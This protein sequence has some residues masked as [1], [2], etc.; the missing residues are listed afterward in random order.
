MRQFSFIYR[1]VEAIE[2]QLPRKLD[3]SAL[4]AILNVSRW[5]LQHEFKRFTGMSVGRYYRLRLL[6]QAIGDVA[7]SDKRIIDIALDFGFESQEAFYRAVKQSFEVSPKN[8][9][10]TPA[11]AKMIGIPPINVHYLE[12]FQIVE[13]E[14]PTEVFFPAR[15][16][17][18]VSRNFA[19]VFFDQKEVSDGVALLW[20]RF[21]HE[22]CHWLHENRQ[23]FTLEYRNNCSGRSGQ[24]QMLA[25]CD[26]TEQATAHPLAKVSISKRKMWQFTLPNEEFIP[27]LFVYFNQV[28]CQQ[29]KLTLRR[30][31]FIWQLD[32]QGKLRFWVELKQAEARLALPSSVKFLDESMTLKPRLVGVLNMQTIPSHLVQKGQR[33][34]YVL[35]RYQDL[36]PVIN[37]GKQHLLIGRPSDYDYTPQH[38]FQVNLFAEGEGGARSIGIE[39]GKYLKCALSGG[40]QKIGE[41]LDSVYFSY[42]NE[43]RYFLRQGFEWITYAEQRA[44]D[45]W[46]IE[47]LI[48]VAKR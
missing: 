21:S 18:G 47:L 27:A 41:D 46:Y 12:F 13:Q 6:T 3:I 26:G 44:N 16:L 45:E 11:L 2:T 10:R 36:L 20:E 7:S 31:P 14:P 17:M 38:D 4:S 5:H 40:L 23:Y 37:A 1:I 32:E 15:D 39:E 48:P 19:S 24:F 29:H 9:R 42:L 35:D 25:T 22:T 8:F 43:S 33:L 30:L 28:F 34:D